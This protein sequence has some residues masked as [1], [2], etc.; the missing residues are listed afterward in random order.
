MAAAVVL[1]RETFRAAL[2]GTVRIDH[3]GRLQA[4]F[5]TPRALLC[6]IVTSSF[7]DAIEVTR[8][9]V[10]TSEFCR[11]NDVNAL[12]SRMLEQ[13]RV[14]AVAADRSA[15]CMTT[16]EARRHF[17]NDSTIAGHPR[18]LANRGTGKLADPRA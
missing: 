17:S 16:I 10:D 2:P 4:M 6:D 8:R 18:D 7:V 13:K 3:N 9:S 14:E 5:G 15:V 12:R 11:L 1:T